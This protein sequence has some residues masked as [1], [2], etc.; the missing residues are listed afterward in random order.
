MSNKSVSGLHWEKKWVWKGRQFGFEQGE[1]GILKGFQT[2]K[3]V[4]TWT[5]DYDP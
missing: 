4:N 1:I 2:E 3:S 5:F